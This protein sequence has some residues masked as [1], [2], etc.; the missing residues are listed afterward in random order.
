[1]NRSSAI[2]LIHLAI[3]PRLVLGADSALPAFSFDAFGTLGLVHSTEDQADFTANQLKPATA[4]FSNSWSADVDSL[5][6]VQV[7][8]NFSDRLTG[9]LQVISELSSEGNFEPHVEWANLNYQFTP[10]FNIR[11]GRYVLP[12]FLA[13]PYRKIGFASSWLR[14][15]VEL[16]AMSSITSNDGINATYEMHLGGALNRVQF[17]IGQLDTEFIDL[18]KFKARNSVRIDNTFEYSA[19][20]LHATYSESTLYIDS[21]KQLFDGFRQLGAAGIAVAEEYDSNGGGVVF[22]SLGANY[23]PGDWFIAGEW[24]RSFVEGTLGDPEAWYVSAGYRIGSVTP[25]FTFAKSDAKVPPPGAGLDLTALPADLVPTA[26]ALNKGLADIHYGS[27]LQQTYSA[28]I[29]WELGARIA[30]NFQFDHT[31]LEENNKGYLINVQPGFRKGGSFNLF[32]AS[33]DFVY[34]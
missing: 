24:G 22:F 15:P 11:V 31:D 21:V 34:P 9:I 6:G 30:V 4:G 18:S 10:D 26:E 25:Y 12:L 17:S 27:P 7:T 20:T 29:R 23:N 8:A 1:M 14:P 28:G 16:Y 5:L 19:L 33:L 3:F 32:S 2:F 13:S